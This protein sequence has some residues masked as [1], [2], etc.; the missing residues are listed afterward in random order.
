MTRQ[1]ADLGVL[2]RGSENRHVSNSPNELGAAG[3]GTAGTD[4]VAAQHLRGGP[5]NAHPTP[6][7]C[8]HLAFAERRLPSW[9]QVAAKVIMHQ[10]GMG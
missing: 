9:I 2:S 6:E 8:G 5:A 1:V 10:T 7:N 4:A 3:P